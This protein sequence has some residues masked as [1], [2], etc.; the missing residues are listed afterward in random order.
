MTDGNECERVDSFFFEGPAA[1]QPEIELT[2]PFCFGDEN[3]NIII[4]RINGGTR[5]FE[6]FFNSGQSSSSQLY[7]NLAGGTY[8]LRILDSNGCEYRDTLTLLDPDQL[9]VTLANNPKRINWGD[10]LEIDARIS[11]EDASFTWTANTPLSC[12][13]CLNPTVKPTEVGI[14]SLTI[15]NEFGCTA[16]DELV[17]QVLNERSIFAPTAFS[18]NGDGI[19]DTFS[20]FGSSQVTNINYLRIY[21]RW[22]ALLYDR[23]GFGPQIPVEEGWDGLSS[24]GDAAPSGI[25]VFSIELVYSDNTVEVLTGDVALLR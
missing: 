24:N 12:M 4:K 17:I 25:Y 18:P 13:D 3:G 1:I 7:G 10:S 23:E 8:P 21:D 20:I 6:F 5:P 2:P 11:Q 14:Y 22:G 19:N 9:T 16:S 15:S